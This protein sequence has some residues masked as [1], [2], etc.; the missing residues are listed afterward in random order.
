MGVHFIIFRSLNLPDRA[1]RLA[2]LAR[3]DRAAPCAGTGCNLKLE[4]GK[5]VVARFKASYIH[6]VKKREKV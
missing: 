2:A 3:Q 6:M 4:E 5:E 1:L